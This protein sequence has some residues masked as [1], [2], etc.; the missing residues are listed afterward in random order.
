MAP[1]G[2]PQ[3]STDM[4]R[5]NRCAGPVDLAR[6]IQLHEQL[7]VQRVPHA[8]LLPGPQPPPAR[9]ARAIAVLARQILPRDPGVQ[10][11]QDPIEHQPIVDRLAAGIA[12]TPTFAHRDQRLDLRPQLVTDLEP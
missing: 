8:R 5:V 10:H 12:P 4:A 6:G 2:A 7:L 11:M 1:S 3:K 9:H